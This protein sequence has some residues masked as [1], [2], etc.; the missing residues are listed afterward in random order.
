MRSMK[1]DIIKGVPG[2]QGKK[3]SLFKTKTPGLVKFQAGLTLTVQKTVTNIAWEHKEGRSAGKA[4][5][6]AA[7][8]GILA[9]PLGLLAGAAI[10]GKKN[11][12][13]TAILT[14]D[15]GEQLMVRMTAKEYEALHSWL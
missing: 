6:G 1:L 11:E 14:L 9:G 8:G 10:G 4:A 15:S 7:A 2:I 5:V 12:I 13:S 3:V